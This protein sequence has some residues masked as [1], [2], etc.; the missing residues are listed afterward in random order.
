MLKK[1]QI[2]IPESKLVSADEVLEAAEAIGFPVVLKAVVPEIL[3]KSD[4]SGVILNLK[5]VSELKDALSKMSGLS[6]TFLVEEMITECVAEFILGMTDDK[7]FGLS[8]TLGAGGIFTELLK[9][10][11]VLMMPLS[12]KHV[13]ESISKLR[14]NK[15]LKG[16]RGQPEGDSEELVETVMSF[17]KFIKSNIENLTGCEINPLI[18][19]PSGKGVVVADALIMMKEK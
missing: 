17:E 3:H 1:H 4:M 12:K 11:V 16:W 7:Q 13:K 9:D 18:V 19:R 5:N 2:N 15:L 10:S 8:L 6:D 14:A